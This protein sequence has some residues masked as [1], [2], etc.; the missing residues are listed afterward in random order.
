M[1]PDIVYFIRCGRRGPV[2]IGKTFGTYQGAMDRLKELQVGN[3]ETL[4]LLGICDGGRDLERQ[5]HKRLQAHRLRG[6]WFKPTAEV[7][8]VIREHASYAPEHTRG[9]RSSTRPVDSVGCEVCGTLLRQGKPDP[10]KPTTCQAC[11]EFAEFR[12]SG[13]AF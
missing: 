13:A 4:Y 1:T 12:A 9:D 2:K 6:E 11:D 7:M 8:D 3:P 10:T 5:L